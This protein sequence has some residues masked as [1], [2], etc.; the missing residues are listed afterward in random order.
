[1]TRSY[2]SRVVSQTGLKLQSQP[3]SGNASGGSLSDVGYGPRHDDAGPAAHAQSDTTGSQSLEEIREI[4][5]QV[6]ESPTQEKGLQDAH[7]EQ[8]KASNVTQFDIHVDEPRAHVEPRKV[9]PPQ[10]VLSMVDGVE[11]ESD[12]ERGAQVTISEGPPGQRQE[13][14]I[15]KTSLQPESNSLMEHAPVVEKTEA[16]RLNDIEER[17]RQRQDGIDPQRPPLLPEPV[18]SE[19]ALEEQANLNSAKPNIPRSLAW[20]RSV[21]EARDW[22][23]ARKDEPNVEA[24]GETDAT[25]ES[26]KIKESNL[27]G[28]AGLEMHAPIASVEGSPSSQDLHLSIGTIQL[29]VE[30]PQ[31]QGV[32]PLPSPAPKAAPS[33]KGSSRLNRRYLRTR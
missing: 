12:N 26:I 28:D 27:Q 32:Q 19:G 31:Q 17:D 9:S 25:S 1:M 4:P 7:D 20:V 15:T 11:S 13:R 2:F 5:S 14:L 16:T 6:I 23:T 33:P 29:T 3:R 10:D 30:E 18:I 24:H 21:E 8:H 22:V